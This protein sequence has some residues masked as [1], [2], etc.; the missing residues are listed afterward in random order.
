LCHN[1]R[2]ITVITIASDLLTGFVT[3]IFRAAG[4]PAPV[5]ATVTSHLVAADCRGRESHGV[6]RVPRYVRQV[7]AKVIR[8]RARMK[9]IRDLGHLL[10]VRGGLNFGHV[11]MAGVMAELLKRV[12]KLG[13]V[14]AFVR[15]CNHIG[16]AGQYLIEPASKG[17]AGKIE[18]N[19]IGLQRVAPF[20]AS[21][22]RFGTNVMAWGF[23]RRES[24]LIV[25]A[26]ACEIVE[27]KVNV[28][29]AEDVPLPHPWLIREDGTLTDRAAEHYGKPPAAILPLGGDTAGQ[30]GSAFLVGLDCWAGILSGSGYAQPGGALGRNA[31]CVTLIRP[32][33]L[34][35]PRAF[36]HR[37]EAYLQSLRSARPRPGV[38]RVLIPGEKEDLLWRARREHGVEIKAGVWKELCETATSLGVALPALECSD[39]ASQSPVF[40]SQ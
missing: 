14:T 22:P 3:N 35:S 2:F 20:G 36:A 17:F 38:E 33:A 5:A 21:Q 11:T 9:V 4:V 6:S 16:E 34:G 18:L 31:L 23:P 8:P 7:Q 12:P 26:S 40:R 15:S 10:M 32:D 19:V 29:R 25:D 13:M 27:G 24:P 30:K 28:A 39:P 37:I 1:E